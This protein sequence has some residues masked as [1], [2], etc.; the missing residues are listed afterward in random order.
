MTGPSHGGERVLFVCVRAGHHRHWAKAGGLCEHL[1]CAA[2][3]PAGD[4]ADHDWM[5]ASTDVFNLTRLGYL[6]PLRDED[7]AAEDDETDDQPMLIP[8]AVR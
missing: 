1:G 5:A 8:R 7:L 2:Y 3:C 4:I 6:R